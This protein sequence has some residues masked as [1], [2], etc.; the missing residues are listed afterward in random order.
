M[1]TILAAIDFTAASHNAA[2]YATELAKAFNARLVI[3]N[4]YLPIPVPLTEALVAV[5]PDDPEPFIAQRL[6]DEIEE[7]DPE[8]IVDL[9]AKFLKGRASDAIKEAARR[10]KADLIVMGMKKEHKDVRRLFG[11]TVTALI[12]K[13]TVPLLVIPEEARFTPVK[14]IALATDTDIAEDANSH[15]ADVLCEIG[16]QFRSKLYVVRI[17]KNAPVDGFQ[18]PNR[19]HNKVS[20]LWP[21][22]LYPYGADILKSL[23]GFTEKNDITILA[24]IPHQHTLLEKWFLP[25]QTRAMAFATHI[26]LLVLPEKA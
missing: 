4:A 7:L 24:M 5:V 22:Y 12:G 14:S 2:I 9:D 6:N 1:K 11:S 19:L 15:I 26:P 16:Q 20:S 3:F 18:R 8:G 17:E 23:Q 21:E 25:S 13:T 10:W